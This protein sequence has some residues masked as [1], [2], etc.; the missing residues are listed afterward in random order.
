MKFKNTD[1]WGFKHAIRGMRN[2]MLSH[3]KSDS[4]YVTLD[5]ADGQFSHL[6]FKDYIIGENDLDLMQRLIKGGSEHRKYLRQIMVSVDI[7]APLYWWKEFDTYKVGTTANSTSFMHKG[8][9]EP[10]NLNQFEL[11][12]QTTN[13]EKFIE[14]DSNIPEEDEIWKPIDG[15]ENYEVS[16]TGK[17]RLLTYSLI[18]SDGVS[19]TY[20]G[21]ELNQ[22]INSSNYKKVILRKEGKGY[23]KYVHRLI[24]QAFIPNPKNLQ[25]VNHI[26]GNKY[27]NNI[28][29]LEWVSKSEN[30]IHAY[31]NELRNIS[32]YNR[33]VVSK[34]MSLFSI[35]D[36]ITIQR[37]YE[38]GLQKKEIAKIFNTYD[39]NI[40][41]LLNDKQRLTQDIELNY[42]YEDCLKIVVDELNNLRDQYF[43]EE[44]AERKKDIWKKIVC[45]L[46]ESW[47]QTR[48]WTANYEVLRNIV[49]QRAGHKLSEWQSFIDWVHTL[50]Y[51][52]EL[53]FYKGEN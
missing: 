34:H 46:P 14:V 22:S 6:M 29:N 47:L 2:P 1:V 31:N 38:L 41:D 7:T 28:D 49:H 50:P 33:R 26:D 9:S 5:E 17:V 24:A 27:N 40:C 15:F 12:I 51:A 21:H 37:L 19:R 32:M 42:S 3:D 30:A 16:N 13:A 35:V 18:D 25:E 44:D 23:N 48:T 43:E 10:F 53:I 36:I 11:N 20:K 4:K 45:L 8:I 39:S 52:E